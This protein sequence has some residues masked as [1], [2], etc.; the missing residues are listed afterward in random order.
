MQ[1]LKHTNVFTYARLKIMNSI[2]YQD[3][4]ETIFFKV[5]EVHHLSVTESTFKNPISFG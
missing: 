4:R 5:E 3:I 2:Y 1:A